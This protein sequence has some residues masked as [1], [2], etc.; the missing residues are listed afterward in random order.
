MNK[1]IIIK[2]LCLSIFLINGCSFAS[3]KAI[4]AEQKIGDFSRIVLINTTSSPSFKFITDLKAVSV[5]PKWSPNKKNFAFISE[6]N[7]KKNLWISNDE[8][9]E[10]EIANY[11]NRE[12][13]RF[14]WAPNSEEIAIEFKPNADEANIFLYSLNLKNFLPITRPDKVANLGSWSPDS[15]WIVF[16]INDSIY[17]SNPKG[18]NEIFITKGS[19][20]IWSPNG[21]YLIFNRT[22]K[23]N[24]SIWIYKDIDKVVDNT[25]KENNKNNYFGE[26]I[27]INHVINSIEYA[28]AFGGNKILYINDLENNKEIYMMDV[29][30]KKIER[31]TNN[32]VDESNIVWSER[33]RSI[34]FTSNA[35]NNSDIYQMKPDGSSQEI[36][37]SSKD[38]FSFLD[39]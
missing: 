37:L 14:E 16:N 17:L 2:I 9:S 31:L 26:N 1:T 7:N 38:N 10:L 15:K 39:W 27:D 21:E 33:Y 23:Q 35:H 24:K 18:V 29:K 34:L 28:W 11:N 3:N 36:I 25:G 12:V 13:E 32:K 8:G 22:E 6:R 4:L 5:K 19:N 20:P 30:S